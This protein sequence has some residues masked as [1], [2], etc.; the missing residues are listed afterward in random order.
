[1]EI[2]KRIV[3]VVYGVGS[4]LVWV[5][6]ARLLASVF[7]II[8]VRDPHIL[9]KDFTATT[10]IAAVTALGV[11]LWTW[12]HGRLRPLAEEVADELTKVTWPT[13]DETKSNMRVTILVSVVVSLILGFFDLVF[14]NLT[15]LIL[16]GT[17]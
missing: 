14:G 5:L 16:G 3:Q 11:L 13:W 10:L 7:G 6:T 4:L 1:M 2:S 9:G 8:G 15:N 12:R 17:T